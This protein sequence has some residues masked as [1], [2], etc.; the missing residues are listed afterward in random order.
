MSDAA[1]VSVP[2]QFELESGLSG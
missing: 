2:A 1:V